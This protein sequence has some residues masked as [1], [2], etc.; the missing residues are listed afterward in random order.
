MNIFL[1]EYVK[2]G[3]KMG[4]EVQA[5]TWNEA[6]KLATFLGEKVIGELIYEEEIDESSG[7]CWR[8]K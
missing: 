5:R 6:E 7:I 4:N 2:N 8:I 1:T 3:K